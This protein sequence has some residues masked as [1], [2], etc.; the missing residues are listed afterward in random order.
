MRVVFAY[1]TAFLVGLFFGVF[2]VLVSVFADAALS[3]R[4]TMIAMVLPAYFLSGLIL[5]FLFRVRFLGPGIL[6]AAAG[7]MVLVVFLIREFQWYMV[8]YFVLQPAFALAGCWTGSRL[9]FWYRYRREQK[10]KT[11]R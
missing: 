11:P 6:L 2:G 7:T 5:C 4:L 1:I 8:P 9:S 3:E 10:G